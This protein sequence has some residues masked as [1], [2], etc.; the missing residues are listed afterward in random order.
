MENI[1][2]REQGRLGKMAILAYQDKSLRGAFERFIIPIN[3]EQFSRNL[4]IK[5]DDTQAPGTQGNNPRQDK[6]PP[7]EIKLDFLFDGTNTIENYPD[8]Y[9]D[10]DVATQINNFVRIVYKVDGEIHQPKFLKVIWG[11]FYME[12][13]LTSLQINYTLFNPDGSPLRAKL[14][15]NFKEY[16]E[17]IKRVKEED[18]NSPDLTKEKTFQEGET[19]PLIAYREYGDSSLYLQLARENNLTSF[20][21]LTGKR[22][23]QLPPIEFSTT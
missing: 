4:K 1:S 7:E 18:K 19:L 6:T 9:K 3:P 21:N 16:K 23:I 2:I 8:E 22:T 13:R 10:Q 17:P 11:T 20:R 5:Q 12:C 15:A 14:S